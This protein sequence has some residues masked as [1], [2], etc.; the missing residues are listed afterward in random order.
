M[1]FSLVAL[2]APAFACE[3]EHKTADGKSGCPM[4]S[5]ATTAELPADGTKATLNVAGMTCGSCAT[6]VQEALLK[7]DGVKAAKINLD[8]KTVEIAFDSTKTNA[9]KLKEAVNATGSYTATL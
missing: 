5:A 3:G 2:S 6:K 1:F 8:A 7:V 4:T 9:E